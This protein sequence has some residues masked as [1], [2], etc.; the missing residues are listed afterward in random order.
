[1]TLTHNFLTSYF[2]HIVSRTFE[3][4]QGWCGIRAGLRD[5]EGY[6]SDDSLLERLAY[7]KSLQCQVNKGSHKKDNIEKVI[8]KEWAFFRGYDIGFRY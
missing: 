5:G 2:V 7:K 3:F 8:D 4:L 6:L 1:M